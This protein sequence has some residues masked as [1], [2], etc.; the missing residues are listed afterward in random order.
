MH[1]RTLREQTAFLKGRIFDRAFPLVRG[2]AYFSYG[3]IFRDSEARRRS[4][5]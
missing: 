2:V 5:G 3:W 4:G 1:H